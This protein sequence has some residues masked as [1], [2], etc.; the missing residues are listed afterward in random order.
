ME[1]QITHAKI[2][3]ICDKKNYFLDTEYKTCKIF[4]QNNRFM[5]QKIYDNNTGEADNVNHSEAIKKG[6]W[7]FEYVS[8]DNV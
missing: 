3:Y 2:Y 6:V 7:L 8:V 4:Y 1:N 5:W